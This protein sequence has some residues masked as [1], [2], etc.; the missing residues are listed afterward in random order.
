MSAFSNLP[1]QA[2]LPLGAYDL[3]EL[4]RAVERAGQ[5]L[6]EADCSGASNHVE[7][8]AAIEKGFALDK[9]FGDDPVELHAS[10]IELSPGDADPAGFVVM[11]RH[12]PEG[13]QFGAKER[14]DL[15]DVFRDAA[16]HFFDADVAFR[17]FYSV[18][19]SAGV[20]PL[21]QH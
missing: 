7:V 20:S 13:A 4:R 17:V 21:G 5:R 10:L 16:D 12:L 11:L 8:F 18:D 19:R 14:N 3:A 1:P 9:P 6:L 2:V 15:L